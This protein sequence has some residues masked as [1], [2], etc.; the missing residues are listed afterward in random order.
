MASG[1][2]VDRLDR[3]ADVHVE[4]PV[5]VVVGVFGD[6]LAEEDVGAVRGD[7][8]LGDPVGIVFGGVAFA[9]ALQAG[10]GTGKSSVLGALETTWVSPVFRLRS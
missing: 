9:C 2:E 4:V 10:K 5:D 1:G 6:L 8:E 3:V 7:V